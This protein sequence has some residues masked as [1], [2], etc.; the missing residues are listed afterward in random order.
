MKTPW[1][2]KI[3]GGLGWILLGIINFLIGDYVI[4]FIAMVGL[5]LFSVEFVVLGF[6]DRA[7]ERK[8]GG[9]G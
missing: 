1:F 6:I 2:M 4:R 5:I 8:K 7:E 3:I 9:R